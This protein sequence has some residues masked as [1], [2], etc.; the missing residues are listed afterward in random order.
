MGLGAVMGPPM[1]GATLVD[2][3]RA[4][5]RCSSSASCAQP[6]ESSSGENQSGRRWLRQRPP[7]ARGPLR[8]VGE[9]CCAAGSSSCRQGVHPEFR[10]RPSALPGLCFPRQRPMGSA[11]RVSG[12]VG[13]GVRGWSGAEVR[14]WRPTGDGVGRGSPLEPPASPG[15][16][17]FVLLGG[18][19]SAAAGP[20]LPLPRLA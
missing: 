18:R 11:V 1:L 8:D 6:G 14:S 2:R 17:R 9:L 16:R 3:A 15:T 20:M 7:P 12:L 4:L 5:S 19:R 10:M 13:A